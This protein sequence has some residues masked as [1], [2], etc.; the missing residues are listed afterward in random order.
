MIA[1]KDKVITIQISMALQ[2]VKELEKREEGPQSLGV[3][4]QTQNTITCAPRDPIPNST[5]I[6]SARDT[7]GHAHSQFLATQFLCS[8]GKHSSFDGKTISAHRDQGSTCLYRQ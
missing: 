4:R 3:N 8:G 5:L 7:P 2:Q 1:D 6:K